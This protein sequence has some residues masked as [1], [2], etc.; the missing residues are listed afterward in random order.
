MDAPAKAGG[1]RDR[2]EL[3]KKLTLLQREYTKTFNILQRAERAERVKSYVKNTVAEQNQLLMQAEED[4]AGSVGQDASKASESISAGSCSE[5]N[6][7]KAPSVSFNLEPEEFSREGPLPENSALESTGREHRRV[8]IAPVWPVPERKQSR[9]SRSRCKERSRGALEDRREFNE[10]LSLE[11]HQS[12]VFKRHSSGFNSSVPKM[13]LAAAAAEQ[14]GTVTMPVTPQGPLEEDGIPR[15]L[16]PLPGHQLEESPGPS[17]EHLWKAG[18]FATPEDSADKDTILLADLQNI[19]K[20]KE[21]DREAKEDLCGNETHRERSQSGES[22]STSCCRSASPALRPAKNSSGAAAGPPLLE[23]G[24]PATPASSRWDS[25]TVV[26][27]LLFPA[28]YYVRT[29]RRMSSC[30]RELNLAAVIQSQLGKR[31]KGQ[32]VALKEQ[33]AKPIPSSPGLVASSAPSPSSDADQESGSGSHVASTE[34]PAPGDGLP[35]SRALTQQSRAGRRKGRRRSRRRP[36]SRG[37]QGLLALMSLKGNSSLVSSEVCHSEPQEQD[38]NQDRAR[39]EPAQSGAMAS[40][41]RKPS[42]SSLKSKAGRAS[43]GGR[44]GRL[45]TGAPDPASLGC[46]GIPSIGGRARLKWLPSDLDLQEFHLPTDE[47]G[48][49]KSEKVKA[50]AKKV[51]E[52]LDGGKSLK[53]LQGVDVASL[54]AAEES[55]GGALLSLEDEPPEPFPFPQGLHTSKLLLSPANAVPEGGTSQLESQLPTSLFPLVGVTPGTQ[56]CSGAPRQAQ[57]GAPQE[58]SVLSA[59]LSTS[60]W[61][62]EEE[63]CHLGALWPEDEGGANWEPGQAAQ[64][65]VVAED[66]ARVMKDSQGGEH[67][68][69]TSK[70]KNFSGS[71]SVDVSAVWWGA[72]DFTELCIVTACE[73]SVALWRHLDSGCWEKVHTWSFAEV[74]VFQ[75]VPLPGAHNLVC[76]ALGGLEIA[77]VRLLSPSLE[78]GGVKQLLV[79]A[80]KIKAA[81][82]LSSRRLVS[83]CDRAVDIFSF[84]EAGGSYTRQALF[85]PEEATLA[86]AA[87]AGLAE[88]LVGL[89]AANCLV[90]WNLRTGQL[91]SRMLL[92]YAYPAPVCH[93][94]YSDSGLLFVVLS[95]PHM[96]NTESG[97]S[98]AFQVVAFNPKTARSC[99]VMTASVPPGH[100]GRYLEGDV[101]DASA[102]A[103]LTSGAIAVW[104]LLRGECTALLPPRA[105]GSWSLVRWSVTD[106][107]LLAGQT[108]GNV[109]IYRYGVRQGSAPETVTAGKSACPPVLEDGRSW[110]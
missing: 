73:T 1:A 66:W 91:L 77:A 36:P 16:S 75:I 23:E 30:Q 34:S 110:A 15:V 94:A 35:Q 26:E 72:A 68:Q 17:P 107:F 8:P 86:F 28:E 58:P 88:A 62:K 27:G 53:S 65:E 51:L 33:A 21:K 93:Q 2:E 76:V 102:A 108:G 44:G 63:R 13:P 14:G 6:A 38:G 18:G 40:P 79:K 57:A 67:L 22:Q 109:C 49:L 20:E 52:I 95:H 83:S 42:S 29:T 45:C 3:K 98:P 47:F 32:G 81:L 25:C 55:L 9:L 60:A 48:S 103:V 37:A 11:G 87:V 100:Q 74:P 56:D 85:P 99:R 101:R 78:D 24:A 4:S 10:G 80:G 96:K 84:P 97:G 46:L 39:V 31:R 7:M 5:T 90:V 41:Q 106:Q 50:S 59:A 70:L 82:G 43:S 92:G 89:T 12:P 19:S 71:C 54:Q 105:E 64:R 69:M 104:D 61:G